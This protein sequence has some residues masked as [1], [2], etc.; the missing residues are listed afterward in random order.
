MTLRSRVVA[1]LAIAVLM[2]A[3]SALMLYRTY[4]TVQSTQNR[5]V[6]QLV[7]ASDELSDILLGS[8]DM[9]SG[10]SGYAVTADEASLTPYLLGKA[11]VAD[12][13]PPLREQLVLGAPD[14]LGLLDRIEGNLAKWQ[15]LA[16]QPEIA[17]VRAGN[18]GDAQEA[19][20]SGVGRRAYTTLRS[21]LAV[22]N[23]Q[24]DSR[25]AA[26]TDQIAELSR[27]LAWLLTIST[28]GS[29]ALLGTASW[30]VNAWVLRPLADLGEQMRHLA[31]QPEA[32]Q[33][34]IPGGPSEIMQVGLD[35]ENLRQSLVTAVDRSIAA[36]EGLAQEGPLVAS[37][38]S[39]LEGPATSEV[40]GYAIASASLSA[41]GV[42]T[43]DWWTMVADAPVPHLVIADVSGHGVPAA[44]I[45]IQM[46]S[47][48]RLNL[49]YDEDL[50]QTLSRFTEAVSAAT[51]TFASCVVVALDDDEIRWLNAGHLP[52]LLIPADGQPPR[53]LQ[54]TGPVVSAIPGTW[55]VCREEMAPGDVLV[56]YT[57]G[58]VEG[59][60][61]NGTQASEADVVSWI[62]E[63][64]ATVGDPDPTATASAFAH[65]LISRARARAIDIRR[66]D[67]TVVVVLRD[68]LVV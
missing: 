48:M 42:V 27:L 39:Y 22:L 46:K 4:N 66:D 60:D 9:D 54:P 63:I 49:Y 51:E 11:Q 2:A 36:D 55:G 13:L 65:G 38:Q 23:E 17:A 12:S 62:A 37:L 15:E 1:L 59:V 10:V 7:P 43:G 67:V 61:D 28:I 24:L 52:P 58:L 8:S 26:G 14:L 41:E 18:Q 45:A 68:P 3:L 44:R 47:F 29:V 6:G 57:D 19:I 33:P 16:L 30:A 5:T 53:E 25:V 34:L 35:A 56:L 20:N 31:S 40:P 21:D 32:Q 64:R 50:P